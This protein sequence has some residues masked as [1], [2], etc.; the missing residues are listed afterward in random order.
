MNTN[1]S[2][3]AVV[4]DEA[5]N[6]LDALLARPDAVR[7]ANGL[8]HTPREIAQQPA[9][10]RATQRL[11]AAQAVALQAFLHDAGAAQNHALTVF[12][13][14]AGT[15]DYIGQCLAPALQ[16]AWGCAVQAVP[17]T[18]L[19][20]EAGDYRRPGGAYLWISFSRSGD[21]SEG[22]AFIEKTRAQFP[23]DRHLVITCNRAG[24]MAQMATRPGAYALVLDEATH[25]QSLAMTS[26]F[27]NMLLA[28]HLLAHLDD[29]ETAAQVTERLAQ[30]GT[31]MLARGAELAQEL[32]QRDFTRA[33]WLGAG[34]LHGAAREA[35]LKMLELTA[36]R[37]LTMAETPLGLRHGPLSALDAGTLLVLFLSQEATRR[38]YEIALL[39]EIR[40]KNLG[41]TI[42]AV[43]TRAD[44]RVRAAADYCLSFTESDDSFPDAYRPLTDVI[45]GQLCGL[46][47]SLRH[48]LQPDTPS[49]NGALTRVVA[50][51]TIEL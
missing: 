36:G 19:L 29:L 5:P 20:T 17:S 14:G 41:V 39:E 3:P 1:E 48:G 34:A 2:C 31:L 45:F 40:A 35:A 30:A 27:T 18:T 38:S 43:A 47:A 9:T 44:S 4:V 16:R 28:G 25:D 11:L 15:S 7:Q 46:F 10:W 32:A 21:S 6:P 8:W 51:L 42:V 37:I 49:P 50:H 24:R 13:V 33:V 26:S 22:V 23:A 12:L